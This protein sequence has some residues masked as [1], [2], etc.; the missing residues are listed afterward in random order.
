M[1]NTR[2]QFISRLAFVGAVAGLDDRLQGQNHLP[3]IFYDQ[4]GLIVHK[5]LDG[6]DTS[7]REGWYWFG[8]WIREHVLNN[9]WTV[10][11]RL[12]IVDV[13]KLLEPNTN[14]VFYRHP[15]LPPWNNPLR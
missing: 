6:G 8:V 13:F 2:R 7:Q 14:G 3:P 4:Y 1:L 15:K 5:G 9:P 11:R 12:G 10:P